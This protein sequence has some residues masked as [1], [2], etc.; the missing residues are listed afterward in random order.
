MLTHRVR[1]GQMNE[2][3]ARIEALSVVEGGVTCIRM[4]HLD[5]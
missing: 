1:E 5:G 2:A 3:V 4:E